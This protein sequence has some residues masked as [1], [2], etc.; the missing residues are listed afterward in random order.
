MT[1]LGIRS[2]FWMMPKMNTKRCQIEPLYHGMSDGI[3]SHYCKLLL[4]PS[5]VTNGSLKSEFLPVFECFCNVIA[6]NPHDMS[7]EH[8]E[9]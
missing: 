7:M 2:S 5:D 4:K 3:I 6:M 9:L 8:N 1:K